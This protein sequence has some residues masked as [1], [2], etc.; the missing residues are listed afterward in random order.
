MIK[1]WILIIVFYTYG[2][3][4]VAISTEK[5][6]DFDHKIECEVVGTFFSDYFD[7]TV[8]GNLKGLRSDFTCVPTENHSGKDMIEQP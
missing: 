3:S 1:S 6:E 5:I 2:P 8:Q 7:S 4:G